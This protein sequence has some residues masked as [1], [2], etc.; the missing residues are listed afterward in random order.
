LDYAVQSNGAPIFFSGINVY[1]EQQSA[2][3]RKSP[4]WLHRLLAAPS[5]LRMASGAA[6]K[7]RPEELGELTI[8]MLRGEEG[9]QARELDD[10]IR[11][12]RLEKPDVVCLSNS[13]LVGLARRIRAEVP[14]RWFV[15]C[16]GRIFFWT[17]F[18]S[19]IAQRLGGWRPN[20]PPRWT[21]SSRPAVIMAN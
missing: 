21:S 3:F 13:L 6:T 15:R 5:L 17:P 19:R 4:D 11:W 9:N 1:L 2:F 20:G 18:P 14:R 10:I 8:S 12:L 7:T 16:K